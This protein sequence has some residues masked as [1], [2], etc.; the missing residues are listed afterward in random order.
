M[1]KCHRARQAQDSVPHG[2]LISVDNI[3]VSVCFKEAVI[4]TKGVNLPCI[5]RQPHLVRQPHLGRQ[6][7]LVKQLER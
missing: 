1:E 5:G 2:S 7:H 4:L 3:A 6:P